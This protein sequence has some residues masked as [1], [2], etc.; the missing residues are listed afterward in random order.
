LRKKR[1]RDFI[2]AK[3]TAWPQ[4]RG[5]IPELNLKLGNLVRGTPLG[6]GRKPS[7]EREMEIL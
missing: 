2:Q 7:A 4:E 1:E 3:E 6:Y 5:R